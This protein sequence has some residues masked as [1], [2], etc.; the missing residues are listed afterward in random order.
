MIVANVSE[1]G[2]EDRQVCTVGRHRHTSLRH[3]SEQSDG[4]QRHGLAA[5]VGARDNKLA[6]VAFELQA[7]RND[8]LILQLQVALKKRMPGAMKDQIRRRA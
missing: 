8:L 4:L 7:D 6:A 3:Q 5:S 1:N 2:L